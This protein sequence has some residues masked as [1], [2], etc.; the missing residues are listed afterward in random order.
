LKQGKK[1]AAHLCI[2][3]S[4]SGIDETVYIIRYVAEKNLD[5]KIEK[6]QD[7]LKFT[8]PIFTGN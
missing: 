7:A 3:F 2:N 8:L 6:K 1:L 4:F 5:Y